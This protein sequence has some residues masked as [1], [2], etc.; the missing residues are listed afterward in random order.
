MTKNT[1]PILLVLSVW[2][3]GCRNHSDRPAATAGVYAYYRIWGE[4]GEEN[5]TCFFQ[6]K[7]KV[8]SPQTIALK[9]PASVE[10]DGQLLSAASTPRTGTYYEA[11]APIAAFSGEHRLAF[12]DASGR[13][14]QETFAYMPFSIVN[15]PSKSI[16]RDSLVLHLKGVNDGDSIRIVLIDT[17]FYSTGI[18]EVQPVT[19]G[20]IHISGEAL[21]EIAA[22]PITLQLIKEE[23][24]PLQ[25]PPA[26]GGH[27]SISYGLTRALELKD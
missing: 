5:V 16:N 26:N 1:L 22:G 24:R 9:E 2:L 20:A 14:Y 27:I 12:T 21:N 8:S 19:D 4:E 25:Q 11:R 3:F 18:N 15:G 10:L 23:E 13:S 17:A 6:F 7:P